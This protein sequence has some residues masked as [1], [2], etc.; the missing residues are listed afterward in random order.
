MRQRFEDLLLR[1]LG[2]DDDA[3][4]ERVKR[5]F[6]S[7]RIE[8]ARAASPRDVVVDDHAWRGAF[9]LTGLDEQIASARSPVV[10]AVSGYAVGNLA[11]EVVTRY[12]RF[13]LRRNDASSGAPFDTVLAAHADLYDATDP[14]QRHDLDHALDAWQWVLRLEPA[15]SLPVQLA[16]LFHDADRIGTD[17]RE[18][19]EHRVPEL[20]S[21]EDAPMR[22]AG[23][24]LVAQLTGLG[25][26]VAD[27][28]RTREIVFSCDRRGTDADVSTLDDADALSFMSLSSGLYSDFFG[29]AQTRR[30]VAYTLSRM[31]ARARSKVEL[32][33]LRPDVERLLRE[34]PSERAQSLEDTRSPGAR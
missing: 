7:L 21:T 32:V 14:R 11:C 27:A 2:E 20:H 28:R 17:P 16:A 31:S 33:R 26:R 25:V 19:I 5:E 9:D 10:I 4:G 34:R 3:D 6:P 12:Q 22:V 24:R 18:R 23:E 30:K 15:A 13:F 1:L 8:R 29:V